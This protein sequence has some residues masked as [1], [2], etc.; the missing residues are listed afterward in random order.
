[1]KPKKTQKP[2]ALKKYS[3]IWPRD[4]AAHLRMTRRGANYEAA[5][6]D[7]QLSRVS[8][9]LASS[10]DNAESAVRNF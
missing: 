6:R 2:C 3:A 7:I 5:L 10:F 9:K 1:M 4:G 8:L